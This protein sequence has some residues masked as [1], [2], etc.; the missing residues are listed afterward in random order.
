M[1]PACTHCS[2]QVPTISFSPPL[3]SFLSTLIGCVHLNS[4]SKRIVGP[5]M[6]HHRVLVCISMLV[7][8][9]PQRGLAS[10][11]PSSI[12]IQGLTAI[13]K[14]SVDPSSIAD[15][16]FPHARIAPSRSQLFHSLFRAPFPLL[17]GHICLTVS[18]HTPSRQLILV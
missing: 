8:P 9:H 15:V 3:Y 14:W 2:I 16:S 18:I 7:P 1:F 12:S 4:F 11:Q 17:I 13:H 5:G 10:R 6:I